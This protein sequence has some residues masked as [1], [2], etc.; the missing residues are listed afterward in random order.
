MR[1]YT[2][3]SERESVKSTYSGCGYG[4]KKS[5]E[6]D[7]R[8]QARYTGLLPIWIYENIYR[9]YWLELQWTRKNRDKRATVANALS[10]IIWGRDA[11]T[12]GMWVLWPQGWGHPSCGDGYTDC[13]QCTWH[14][15]IPKA[16][17]L[18]LKSDANK[19]SSYVYLFNLSCSDSTVMK[20][21]SDYDSVPYV[22]MTQGREWAD[23][24]NYTLSPWDGNSSLQI[25]KLDYW[26]EIS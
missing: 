20:Q 4:R 2:Q 13:S 1:D 23:H 3:T 21:P 9:K 22:I 26:G 16:K 11:L 17:S 5:P 19:H 15:L 14:I 6:R 8:S 24:S 18:L 12:E 10:S 25:N 7:V